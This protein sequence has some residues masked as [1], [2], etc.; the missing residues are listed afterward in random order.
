MP[1]ASEHYLDRELWQLIFSHLEGCMRWV[2]RLVCKQWREIIPHYP[3]AYLP[4]VSEYVARSF[5]DL[6][7]LRL[8]QYG[9]TDCIRDLCLHPLGLRLRYSTKVPMVALR[10]GHAEA[11]CALWS[12]VWAEPSDHSKTPPQVLRLLQEIVTS[13]YD[14]SKPL[15]LVLQQTELLRHIIEHRQYICWSPAKMPCPPTNL[16]TFLSACRVDTTDD[17]CWLAHVV[18]HTGCTNMLAL[19]SPQTYLFDFTSQMMR[20][21]VESDQV[22]FL[23][24]LWHSIGKRNP[25]G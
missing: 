6:V 4:K 10:G 5:L 20:A 1:C 17:Q 22:H 15:S 11:F 19:L 7:L 8:A 14:L 12:E 2:A 13:P 18:A 25:L 3:R 16:V 9:Y 23:R 21:A 24:H